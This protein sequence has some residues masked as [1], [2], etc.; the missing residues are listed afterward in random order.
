LW[1]SPT[2]ESYA[3][4]VGFFERAVMLEPASVE[5]R[6]L[7]AGTLS[8]RAIF[9]F[10]GSAAADLVRAETL[11]G[12]ALAAS[13]LNPSAH[14]AKGQ[15]LYAQHRCEEAIPSSKRRSRSTPTRRGPLPCLAAANFMSGRARRGSRF[16][17]RPSASAPATPKSVISLS[18]WDYC[19]CCY[20]GLMRRSSGFRRREAPRRHYP[21]APLSRRGLWSQGRNRACPR[22]ARG[23][24][25]AEWSR[26]R[27]EHYRT[28][29]EFASRVA[30]SGCPIRNHRLRRS[31]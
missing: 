4:A 25:P 17:S 29:G 13:P 12:Q 22:R 11:V 15:L 27:I 7:L 9:N 8:A 23:S 5:A 19:I 20:P 21:R 16:S 14:H 28:E 24:Q 3:E 31:A 6:S 30:G 18:G 10:T 26:P 1:K 2:A